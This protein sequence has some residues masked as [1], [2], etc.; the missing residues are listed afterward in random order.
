M[1]RYYKQ[2]PPSGLRKL[3]GGI[4]LCDKGCSPQGI[5]TENRHI[6]RTGGLPVWSKSSGTNTSMGTR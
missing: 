3:D 2:I 6:R 4:Y 1:A 5:P